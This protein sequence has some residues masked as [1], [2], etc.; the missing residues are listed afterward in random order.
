MFAE[1]QKIRPSLQEG[2]I[3]WSEYFQRYLEFKWVMEKSDDHT[4]GGYLFS[5][6]G[7]LGLSIIESSDIYEVPSLLKELL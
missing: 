1:R 4:R 6:V 5:H 2:D 3:V 7:R